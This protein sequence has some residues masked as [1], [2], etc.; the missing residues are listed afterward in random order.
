[1]KKNILLG[2]ILLCA[3]IAISSIAYAATLTS[4]NISQTAQ[5]DD[6]LYAFFDIADETGAP[7]TGLAAE[8]ITLTIGT[9]VLETGLYTVAQSDIGVGYVFA[10]DISKSLSAKQFEDVK[11]ALQQWISNMGEKD[12]AAILT[13]GEEIA[14]QTDFT[15]DTNILNTV[16][17]KLSPSDNKTQLYNGILRTLD[18]ARRQSKDLPLRRVVLILSDGMDD[19]PAGATMS[20]VTSKAE[21]SGIPMYVV[22]VEGKSNQKELNEL[23]GVARL[24]GGELYLASS[25]ALQG[26]YQQVYTRIQNGYMAESKLDYSVADGTIKGLMLAVRQGGISVEDSVDIRLKALEAPAAT[27]APASPKP[28]PALVTFAD[29]LADA[30]LHYEAGDYEE[31]IADGGKGIGFN[32]QI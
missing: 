12:H 32:G 8:D 6:T 4:A 21:Q 28:T 25:D 27:I 15:Q 13:F 2:L 18:I 9:K 30:L 16:A 17:E 24:S 20:E 29:L 31:A 14:I 23:G 11:K 5:A 10:V 1:M 19:F 22:G 26:G 7:V 3:T